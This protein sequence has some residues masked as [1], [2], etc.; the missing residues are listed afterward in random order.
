M[1]G[2]KDVFFLPAQVAQV[3]GEQGLGVVA[4]A[5][6]VVV[7][8]GEWREQARARIEAHVVRQFPRAAVGGAVA[9]FVQQ[10]QA[11]G[12][13][14]DMF[15]AGAALLDVGG[16]HL[17]LGREDQVGEIVGHALL[18][19]RDVGIG[20]ADAETEQGVA[21]GR[22]QRLDGAAA[23]GHPLDP[24][25]AGAVGDLGAGAAGLRE[26]RAII[27]ARR[28]QAVGQGRRQAQHGEH[29]EA[30]HGHATRVAA[31]AG[32]GQGLVGR[33]EAGEQVR[34]ES[35]TRMRGFRPAREVQAAPAR[36][37]LERVVLEHLRDEQGQP[38][39]ALAQRFDELE[40]RAALGGRRLGAQRG[41]A[42]R[43]Q[44]FGDR[45]EHLGHASATGGA[46]H[47]VRGEPVP[48]RL[49]EGLGRQRRAHLRMAGQAFQPGDHEVHRHPHL[50]VL[51]RFVD[52][53]AQAGGGVP[54]G[55]RRA[56]QGL[57]RHRDHDPVQGQ[58]LALVGELH[59]R[60][61]P[62][63][64]IEPGI[65]VADHARM[66]L[67][68]DHRLEEPPAPD[69]VGGQ[70]R[71]VRGR[72][73]RDLG[74]GAEQPVDVGGGIAHEQHPR[75]P[76]QRRAALVDVGRARD[77]ALGLGDGGRHPRDRLAFI[78]GIARAEV[79]DPLAGA[80]LQRG[81]ALPGHEPPQHHQRDHAQAQHLPEAHRQQ[82]QQRQ[83]EEHEP[84]HDDQ[85]HQGDHDAPQ[86]GLLR[87]VR[88]LRVQ[89]TDPREDRTDAREQAFD[90]IQRV[91][92]A[93]SMA[94]SA[95][96]ASAAGAGAWQAASAAGFFA[97]SDS[98]SVC[99]N[100]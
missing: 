1:F 60:L 25:A 2:I 91:H 81:L 67:D 61:V 37:A 87:G 54:Q 4:V 20:A 100:R 77:R 51:H 39:A 58:L 79:A 34:D 48:Q 69:I 94:G 35:A 84:G 47:F 19:R 68:G 49:R 28:L 82:R 89:R 6:G 78:L 75:D 12:D 43:M 72:E 50:Q 27:A 33:Q 17:V 40:D 26:Q 5:A 13:R 88:A 9:A 7:G 83:G 85:Q 57:C 10:A 95:V 53:P 38:R 97:G 14:E 46:D 80:P 11:L 24:P 62:E 99:M 42:Q 32:P 66:H 63:P 52:Q 21:G 93:G 92:G 45:F 96:A 16:Q 36:G 64:A 76:V 90:E 65:G 30:S 55:I 59:Q 98:G 41:H 86:P 74:A 70:R 73:R 44:A 29:A 23:P 3:G 31:Q 8:A 18:Q 71:L 56:Q 15:D 22:F